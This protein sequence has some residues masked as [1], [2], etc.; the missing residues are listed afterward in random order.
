MKDKPK[1][2]IPENVSDKK[3]L[4]EVLKAGLS[5]LAKKGTK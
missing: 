4:E 2:A 5:P 1:P 3:A